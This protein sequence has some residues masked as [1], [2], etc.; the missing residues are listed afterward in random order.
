MAKLVCRIEP[1]AR[2][3]RCARSRLLKL[4][5]QDFAD[6]TGIGVSVSHSPGTSKWN[7]IEHRLFSQISMK[8][9]GRPLLSHQTVARP[10]AATRTRSGL[11]V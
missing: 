11:K 4:E 10:I 9:R 1:H 2:T 8:W 5:L 6:M 3:A 7:K